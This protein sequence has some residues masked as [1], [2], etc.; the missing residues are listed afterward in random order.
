ML[1]EGILAGSSVYQIMWMFGSKTNLDFYLSY[2][3]T[4]PMYRILFQICGTL[5]IMDILKSI[6]DPNKFHRYK[7]LYVLLLLFNSIAY[8]SN[9]SIGRYEAVMYN[10][11]SYATNNTEY[12]WELSK[13]TPLCY[14][15]I[16]N[17]VN[18]SNIQ[19]WMIGT[20][21]KCFGYILSYFIITY[22]AI[23]DK[24]ILEVMK[25]N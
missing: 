17:S 9:L 3:E 1:F 24:Q 10:D 5:T 12:M 18:Q 14:N 11:N 8:I 16:I 22:I 23:N 2:I 15:D 13:T 20:Y 21:F 19:N 7:I 25:N 4:A 6:T